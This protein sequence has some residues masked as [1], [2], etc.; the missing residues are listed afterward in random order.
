MHRTVSG[1]VATEL[2]LMPVLLS[3]MVNLQMLLFLTVT[4]KLFPTGKFRLQRVITATVSGF[5]G[6]QKILLPQKETFTDNK[7][8]YSKEAT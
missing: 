2:I 5:P 8:F 6:L 4:S 7:F 1:T 3:G